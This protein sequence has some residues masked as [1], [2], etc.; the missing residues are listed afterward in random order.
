VLPSGSPRIRHTDAVYS[1]WL[2]LTALSYVV[3]HHLGLLPDGLGAGPDDTRWTDWLDLAV[4]WLVLVPA[5]LTLRADGAAERTWWIFGAGALAYASGH[6][7]HLAANSVGNAHLSDTAHLW[8]EVVGH[9]IWYAGVALVLLALARTMVGRPRAGWVGYLL[10]VAVGLTWASNA[11]GGG[12]Q[13]L[14]AIVAV[15][16]CGFGWR[17]RHDLPVVLLVGFAPVIPVLLA[18]WAC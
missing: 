16:T 14:A 8:D 7:I 18:V 13:A 17:H 15:I 2:A 5:A 6:G 9:T 12:T 10:A 11:L 4:P 3:L 1:R